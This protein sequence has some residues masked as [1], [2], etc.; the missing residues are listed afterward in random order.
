LAVK[1]LLTEK[2]PSD[3]LAPLSDAIV[4]AMRN[5]K[6]GNIIS[7]DLRNLNNR[8]VDKFII[9]HGDNDR[10]VEAIAKEVEEHVRK[11]LNDKP[12]HREGYENR[13]WILLDYVNIVVHVFLKEKRDFYAIEELWGDAE[14]EEFKD[15]S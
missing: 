6:A 3:N 2:K 4:E 14:L 12:W 7:L 8:Y 13:E 9:C 10:Q 15:F 1:P 11:T 5:K